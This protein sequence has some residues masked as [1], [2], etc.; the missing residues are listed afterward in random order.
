MPAPRLFLLA[1]LVSFPAVAS[2]A[3]PAVEFNRDI[4]P[5]L[6]NHCF[7]CHGPDNNLRKAKLRLDLEKDGHGVHGGM[8]V[9]EPGKPEES[10][11]FARITSEEPG[12]K[13]PPP[14][15]GLTPPGSP[16]K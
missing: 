12:R 8:S 3:E 7:V 4:R 16:E 14:P 11:L 1:F 6:S 13:M 10:E 2:A 9:L 5:I 15:R